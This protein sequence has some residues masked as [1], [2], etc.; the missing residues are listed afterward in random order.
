M[1]GISEEAETSSKSM[2][3]SKENV[4]IEK[5]GI[6]IENMVLISPKSPELSSSIT[7][8]SQE[9]I[10]TIKVFNISGMKTSAYTVNNN[11]TTISLSELNINSSGLY[12]FSIETEDGN[13]SQQKVSVR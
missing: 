5:S 3:P 10:N 4:K 9:K 2:V 8:S 11:R 7:I 6:G 1:G 13:T 12:I